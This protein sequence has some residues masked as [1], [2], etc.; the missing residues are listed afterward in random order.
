MNIVCGVDIVEII[1]I[2]KLVDRRREEALQ[3]IFTLQE[4]SY[5]RSFKA[6]YAE[7]F[8]GRFA[9]KEAVLKVLGKGIFGPVPINCIEI[10]NNTEG[11][12]YL[13]LKGKALE[14]YNILSIASIDISISHTA[15]LAVG[16]ATALK[17]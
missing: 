2:K 15:S 7:K 11:K 9:V 5:C 3:S 13:V 8:A 6:N 17:E 12:P 16:F 1:R 14:Y 10:L 4:I